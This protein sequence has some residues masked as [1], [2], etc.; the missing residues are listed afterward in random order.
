VLQAIRR[1]WISALYGPEWLEAS[2]ST[3]VREQ[4]MDPESLAA[5]AA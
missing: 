5:Y 4:E 2:T 3:L 1:L